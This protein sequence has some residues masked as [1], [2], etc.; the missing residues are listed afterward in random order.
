MIN[1]WLLRGGG[2]EG[3]GDAW[4]GGIVGREAGRREWVED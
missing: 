1:R 2:E 3:A 4:K